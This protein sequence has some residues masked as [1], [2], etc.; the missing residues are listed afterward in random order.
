[1][2]ENWEPRMTALETAMAG[3]LETCREREDRHTEEIRT[4]KVWCRAVLLAQGGT[5]LGLLGLF[6]R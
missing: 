1:M 4:V 3:H 6:F 2:T 5:V